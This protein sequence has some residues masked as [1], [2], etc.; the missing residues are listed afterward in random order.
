MQKDKVYHFFASYAITFVAT[1]ILQ[2][3]LDSDRAMAMGSLIALVIGFL[4][5]LY[6]K[7]VKKTYIS[8]SDLVADFIGIVAAL[9]PMLLVV[10]FAQC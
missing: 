8:G 7:Y 1:G 5:E 9:L 10:A 4:K 6:D 3:C 2:F